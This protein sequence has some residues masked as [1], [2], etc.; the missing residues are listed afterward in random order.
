MKDRIIQKY[1]DDTP[2][3]LT[4]CDSAIIGYDSVSK[5][6][7]YSRGLLEDALVMLGST[8]DETGEH[9]QLILDKADEPKPIV[10]DTLAFVD[11]D[12]HSN[13]LINIIPIDK[14]DGQ[15]RSTLL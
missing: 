4:G 2:V 12:D 11:A 10:A 9:I 1:P 7:I 14:I 6:V 3:Y 15:S 5:R 13:A 8:L